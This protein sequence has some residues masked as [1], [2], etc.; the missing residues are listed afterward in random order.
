MRAIDMALL[1][2]WYSCWEIHRHLIYAVRNSIIFHAFLSQ[3]RLFGAIIV[4]I[5]G[6]DVQYTKQSM[7]LFSFY[8]HHNRKVHTHKTGMVERKNK[9]TKASSSRTNIR[10]AIRPLIRL[11]CNFLVPKSSHIVKTFQHQIAVCYQWT[12]CSLPCELNFSTVSLQFNA[13]F[14]LFSLSIDLNF[15]CSCW[16][17]VL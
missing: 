6:T 13:F 14:F 12:D 11:F 7:I 15:F 4:R 17:F 16:F 3:R 5:G 10:L 2:V 8:I 1:C 9:R